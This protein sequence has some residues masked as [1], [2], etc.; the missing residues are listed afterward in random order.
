MLELYKQQQQNIQHA[1]YLF[2]AERGFLEGGL[3]SD[4]K[5][6]LKASFSSDGCLAYL[7]MIIA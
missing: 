4:S 3:P 1:K 5:V 6:L 2:P 7:D